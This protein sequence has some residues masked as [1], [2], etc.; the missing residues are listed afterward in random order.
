MAKKKP[1]SR[2]NNN[3]I[4]LKSVLWKEYK[5][6]G[7]YDW[8]SP[9]FN[10]L[11]S[12]TYDVTGKKDPFKVPHIRDIAAGVEE[13]LFKEQI[14]NTYQIPYYDINKTLESFQ[15]EPTYKGYTV[16]TNFKTPEFADEKFKIGNFK[17]DGSQFQNLV[18]KTDAERLKNYSSSP[19]AK[20]TVDINPDK[21]TIKLYVGEEPVDQQ[22]IKKQ[23]KPYK[24][25]K[26]T[27]GNIKKIRN[28][29]PENEAKI[30]ELERKLDIEK[31]I[32]LPIFKSGDVTF[33]EYI[34]ESTL[35]IKEWNREVRQL[36][37]ENEDLRKQLAKQDKGFVAKP[38][39]KTPKGNKGRKKRR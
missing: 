30:K 16:I 6:E 20:I 26:A 19:P 32:L 21:K 39:K 17:Y 3:W 22:K 13:S 8:N 37:K 24:E 2:R 15:D 33:D 34:H 11:V 28:S 1:K 36:K 18:K 38:K 14:R 35:N 12:N 9:N 29:I 25:I 23:V 5:E 10:K 4:Q 31:T 27:P 7:L